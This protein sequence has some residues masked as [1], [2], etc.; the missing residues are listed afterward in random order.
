MSILLPQR[1]LSL[2]SHHQH[3]E[4]SS[5]YNV[6][7]KPKLLYSIA[8]VELEEKIRRKLVNY[9]SA[10]KYYDGRSLLDKVKQYRKESILIVV[11]SNS[12]SSYIS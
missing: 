9:V 5:E 6:S 3:S 11:L 8:E 2:Y 12:M 10:L 7:N 1:H 4:Q